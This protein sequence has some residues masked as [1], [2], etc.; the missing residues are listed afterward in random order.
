MRINKSTDQLIINVGLKL[1]AYELRQ[2]KLLKLLLT[3]LKN[4]EPFIHNPK[5]NSSIIK[6]SPM[7]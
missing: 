2:N 3:T 5:R 1:N 6:T 7:A 4:F